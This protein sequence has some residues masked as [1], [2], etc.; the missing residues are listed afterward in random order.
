MPQLKNMKCLNQQISV[1]QNKILGMCVLGNG[2]GQNIPCLQIYG[3]SDKQNS[4]EKS[5]MRTESLNVCR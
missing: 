3:T 2:F 5:C 1:D 4:P